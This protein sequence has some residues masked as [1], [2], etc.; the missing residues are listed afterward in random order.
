[1]Y[2]CLY[3]FTD[4]SECVTGK[5]ELSNQFRSVFFSSLP[6]QGEDARSQAIRVQ[7]IKKWQ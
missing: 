4:L 1:V 3:V 6:Q 2:G 5:L 7:L